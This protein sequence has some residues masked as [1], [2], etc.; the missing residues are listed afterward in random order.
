MNGRTRRGFLGGSAAALPG[1]L[2]VACGGTTASTTEVPRAQT[3]GPVKLVQLSRRAGGTEALTLQQKVMDDFKQAAPNVTVEVVPGT[4]PQEQLVVRHAGGDPVDFVE[5]DWGVWVDLAD[6]KVVEDLTPYFTRDKMDAGAFLGEALTSYTYQ[7]KRYAMPVSMSVDGLWYNDDLFRAGG[8]KPPPQDPNDR[9]WT[10]DKFM[11]TARQLSKPGQQFGFGGS[12]NCF[13]TLGVTDG[14][15]YGQRTW[16]DAKGKALMDTENFRKGAQFWLDLQWK[17]QGIWPTAAELDQI[18]Q[19]PNQAAHVTGKVAMNV[20]CALPPKDQM[21]MKWGMAALPYSG[22][23]KNI[24]GRMY[25]HALHMGAAGKNKD[26][27]WQLFRWLTKPE[28]ASRYPEVAGHS[29]SPIKGGSD[30]IQKLRKD[31]YGVDLSVLLKNAET[32]II[33]GLGMLKYAGWKNVNDEIGKRHT[34]EFKQNK[35]SVG[36]WVKLATEAFDRLLV[37]KK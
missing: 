2:L 27:V 14:T 5:N 15:Y 20:I 37:P 13:P 24:S 11:E 12:Y 30:A 34:D 4:V 32:Q 31:Q 36:D 1:V 7:N 6:G 18:R 9:S 16:D 10:L 33:S 17:Q 19:Q 3:T 8:V 26:T 22:T 23:G 21:T 28:N 29:V 25:P 35:L